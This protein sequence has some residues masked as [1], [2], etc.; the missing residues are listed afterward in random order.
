MVSVV[1]V[2]VV[3]DCKSCFDPCTVGSD[4]LGKRP[5]KPVDS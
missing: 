5:E 3:E 2:V 1:V 4:V